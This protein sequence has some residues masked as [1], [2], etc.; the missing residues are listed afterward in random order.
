MNSIDLVLLQS[1]I[2]Q[3]QH[4]RALFGTGRLVADNLIL[5]AAHLLWNKEEGTGPELEGWQVR[6]E[7]DRS[8]NNWPFRNGNSVIWHDETLGFALI[9]LGNPQDPPLRPELTIRV[10]TVTTSCRHSVE[11]RGY[12]PGQNPKLLMI[13]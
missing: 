7:R 6:L 10:A 8:G 2:A 3:V 1:D 13:S 12:P 11:A 4:E 9:R 5:T